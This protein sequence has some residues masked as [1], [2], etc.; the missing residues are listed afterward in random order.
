M[1]CQSS[2]WGRDTPLTPRTQTFHGCAVPFPQHVLIDLGARWSSTLVLT[3]AELALHRWREDATRLK[4]YG[5]GPSRCAR[6]EALVDRLRANHDAWEA[7]RVPSSPSSRPPPIDPRVD[8]DRDVR[9]RARVWLARAVSILEAAEF[10]APEAGVALTSIPPPGDGTTTALAS[11][12]AALARCVALRDHLDPEAADDEFFTEANAI[13]EALSRSTEHSP[14]DARD[15]AD[16]LD[17]L[18]GEVYLTIRGLNRAAR[19][20]FTAAPDEAR[21]E[22]YVFQFLLTIG[23]G[24]EEAPA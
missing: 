9:S 11:V 5:W 22:K 21:A 20:A 24:D 3:E 17:A 18:D 16:A 8:L 7:P 14:L 6:F 2:V 4:P 19:R 15:R 10:D 1:D 23:R 13:K 12:R